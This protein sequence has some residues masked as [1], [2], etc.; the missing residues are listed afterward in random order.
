MAFAF[1]GWVRRM[2]FF[3]SY[4]LP[5]NHMYVAGG[6]YMNRFRKKPIYGVLLGGVLLGMGIMICTS[7]KI[8]PSSA[9]FLR[10]AEPDIILDAGHGA[11][12]NTINPKLGP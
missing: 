6:E 4:P 10:S 1:A 5:V 3:D 11:S 9:S 12:E 2:F 8:Q 7:A